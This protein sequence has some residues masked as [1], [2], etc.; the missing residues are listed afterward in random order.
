MQSLNE[1]LP[2]KLGKTAILSKKF[3]GEFRNLNSPEIH[4]FQK[5]Q[6]LIIDTSVQKT[7]IEK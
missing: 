7:T 1:F 6:F 5:N 2:I 4:F 3:I